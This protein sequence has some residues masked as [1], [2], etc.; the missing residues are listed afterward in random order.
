M[1]YLVVF[2]AFLLVF[3]LPA[4]L[5]AQS[6]EDPHPDLYYEVDDPPVPL[7]LADIRR[8]IIYPQ[9]LKQ[10]GIQGTLVIRVLVDTLG[11][12][13]KYLVLKSPHP[14]FEK[15]VIPLLPELKFHPASDKNV[16]TKFWVLM[17]FTFKLTPTEKE[18]K[19]G[20]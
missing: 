6:S 18:G 2:F 5:C 3:S 8:K 12:V 20:Q 13:Q 17:P 10:E 14:G 11:L 9:D 15:A 1:R 16:K 7:N 4:F 19:S